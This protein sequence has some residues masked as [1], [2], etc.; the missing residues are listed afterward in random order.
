MEDFYLLLVEVRGL[1]TG[2]RGCCHDEQVI[3]CDIGPSEMLHAQESIYES[4]V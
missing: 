3:T 2:F 1:A 4:A